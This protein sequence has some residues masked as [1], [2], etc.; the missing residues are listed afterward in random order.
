MDVPASLIGLLKTPLDTHAEELRCNLKSVLLD[1][2]FPLQP[3][4]RHGPK[5]AL[6]EGDKLRG[7]FLFYVSGDFDP[8]V[9]GLSRAGGRK[10]GALPLMGRPR[11]LYD[12][13]LHDRFISCCRKENQERASKCFLDTQVELVEQWITGAWKAVRGVAPELQGFMSEHDSAWFANLDTGEE[14]S[15]EGSGLGLR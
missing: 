4:L 2:A 10:F 7:V 3:R 11:D 1:P 8:M 14:T 5:P 6:D 13:D 9:C 15:I 12:D